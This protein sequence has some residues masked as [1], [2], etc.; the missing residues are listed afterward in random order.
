[1][2]DVT[3]ENRKDIIR[4]YA[5]E[6][7]DGM[8]WDTLYSFAYEKIVESKGLMDNSSLKNEIKNYCPNVLED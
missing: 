2:I 5:S 7:L 1:M 3:D 8:D 6:L 4:A